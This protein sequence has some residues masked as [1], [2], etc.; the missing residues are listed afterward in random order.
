[1][2]ESGKISPYKLVATIYESRLTGAAAENAAFLMRAGARVHTGVDATNL[3]RTFGSEQFGNIVWNFPFA[4]GTRNIGAQQ[5]LLNGFFQSGSRHL[6]SGGTIQVA[7]KNGRPYSS[8]GVAARAEKAGLRLLGQ[9]AF[10]FGA[11][12]GYS[13]AQTAVPGVGAAF[14]NGASVYTFGR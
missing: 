14:P 3:A 10:N 11:F 13:N 12:P 7:L 2:V 6:A 1:M 9:D 8:W 5:A 4:A